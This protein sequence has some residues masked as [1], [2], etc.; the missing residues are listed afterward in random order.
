MDAKHPDPIM[1]HVLAGFGARLRDARVAAGYNNQ[2]AF[3][4]LLGISAYRYNNWEQERHPPP[5]AYLAILK[6]RFGIGADWILS[7]DYD[8]LSSRTRDAL[9]Q[10]V[11]KPPGPMRVGD[12]TDAPASVRTIPSPDV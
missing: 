7:G 6:Q 8:A 12:D 10:N 3:A 1:S 4:R 5:P 11:I 2:A 9:M